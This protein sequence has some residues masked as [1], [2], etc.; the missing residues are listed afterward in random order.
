MIIVESF[1]LGSEDAGDKCVGQY[2]AI[3][4]EELLKIKKWCLC[5]VKPKNLYYGD[6]C[7]FVCVSVSTEQSKVFRSRAYLLGWMPYLLPSRWFLSTRKK[8]VV[9]QTYYHIKSRRRRVRQTMLSIVTDMETQ[10]PP[11]CTNE[12]TNSLQWHSAS[13]LCPFI[14]GTPQQNDVIVIHASSFGKL[15][16]FGWKFCFPHSYPQCFLCCPESPILRKKTSD[17]N[18]LPVPSPNN[19]KWNW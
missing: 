15:I 12:Q 10:M 6:D 5:C 1:V 19:D 13:K 16:V 14:F 8:I 11:H 3:K 9:P 18:F 17:S 4:R 7:V 2:P